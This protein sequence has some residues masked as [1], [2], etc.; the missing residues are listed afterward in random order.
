M[1]HINEL[2]GVEARQLCVFASAGGVC[3]VS[4]T[5]T[6]PKV[7]TKLCARRGDTPRLQDGQAGIGA[8]LC[9]QTQST[10]INKDILETQLAYKFNN[11]L[12]APVCASAG[13]LDGNLTAKRS[14]DVRKPS[15]LTKEL[16]KGRFISLQAFA[17]DGRSAV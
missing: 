12:L 2:V 17:T 6:R 1:H 14:V 15:K 9:N 11:L 7:V 8:M 13:P 4:R 16:S 3:V 10:P 5:T